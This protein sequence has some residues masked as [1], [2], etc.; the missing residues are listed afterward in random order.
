M[1][2]YSPISE[3]SGRSHLDFAEW[4]AL[5]REYVSRRSPRFDIWILMRTLP[6][7]IARKGAY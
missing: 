7:V 6:A 3:T 2:P 4:M 1:F 5:D